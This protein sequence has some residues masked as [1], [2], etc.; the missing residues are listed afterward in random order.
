MGA[1]RAVGAVQPGWRWG[2][3]TIRVPFV[4]TG[5]AGSELLQGVIVASA[6][7][8][9]IVPILTGSMGLTFEEAVAVA[10]I[11]ATG[12]ASSWLVFGEPYAPGWITPALP[13]TLAYVVN[14]SITDVT[15]RWHAM[16]AL[17]VDLALILIL[18]GITGIGRQVM[19]YMPNALKA[20]IIL[21]AAI[22]A[23]LQVLD[24]SDPGNNFNLQPIATTA[25]IVVCLVTTFSNPFRALTRKYRSVGALSSL[26]LLPGFV[27][28]A[29]VG[30]LVGEVHYDV[31]W[32]ILIPPFATLWAKA[33]PFAIG[34]PDLD[35]F[36][37]CLPLAFIGYVLVF[38]DLV[39]GDQVLKEA[40]PDRPDEHIA[41]DTNRSHLALGAR[42]L[43]TALIA[44]FFPTQGALWTG[45]HVII[46][47]RWRQGRTT[48]DSLYDGIAG[49]YVYALP[50]V[51]FILPLVTG[52][53]GLFEIALVL[54][55]TLTAF[56]CAYVAISMTRDHTEQGVT[57]LCGTALALFD[58]LQ[59]L[60]I[61]L[62]A[63]LLLLGYEG[64]DNTVDDVDV[65]RSRTPA[66]DEGLGSVADGDA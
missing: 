27:V 42:N 66:I 18:F 1:R 34:W 40:Q 25:A 28:A 58:P 23:L 19:R 47:Q 55:L 56:A 49:Y 21:G 45:V 16:C 50:L 20:G 53:Q 46:V 48:M 10:M 64:P 32:G 60:L 61:G 54:T 4:H 63:C 12:I 17:T 26:G 31:Q 11:A 41:I 38:G 35:M 6:T 8:F 5:F 51:Y 24:M 44:P 57:L 37:A 13:F 52:L 36:L 9:G 59:G 65:A 62:A 22:A 39:T 30:P 3:F 43:L 29:V 14:G 2:P 7:G 15:E 33:S